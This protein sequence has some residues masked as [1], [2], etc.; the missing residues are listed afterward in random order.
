MHFKLIDILLLSSGNRV[1]C[2]NYE[3]TGFF[4]CKCV[5]IVKSKK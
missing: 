1:N 2:K 4:N 5:K 3:I